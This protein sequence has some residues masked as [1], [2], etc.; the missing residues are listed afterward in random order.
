[1]APD[2]PELRRWWPPRVV[3]AI[4]RLWEERD[5]FYEALERLPQTFCHGDAIRRNLLAGADETVAIDWEFAGHYAVGE[6]V[7]QTLS[8][9]SAF[10]DVEPADLPAIDEALFANYLDGL[11]EAGWRGNTTEVRFAYAAHAALRN[12]FNTVGAFV[13]DDRRRHGGPGEIWPDLGGACRAPR[14]HPAL[15]P[16]PRRRG[17]QA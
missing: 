5:T 15:P 6:E 7:G 9:A 2:N 1:M 10:Y 4:L 11:R 14:C 16:R 8:V 13:P 17:S 12:L 3:A